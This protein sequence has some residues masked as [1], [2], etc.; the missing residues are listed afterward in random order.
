MEFRTLRYFIKVAES[1]S[2]SSAAEKLKLSQ[3]AL[4]RQ[5]QMMEDELGLS[6]FDRAG[7]KVF[8]TAAGVD[9]LERAYEVQKAVSSLTTRASELA[10]GTH[11]IIRV[12]ATPQ[13]LESLISLTLP[14]F[15][16]KHPGAQILLMES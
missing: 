16:S 4:S 7:R 13:T 15:Q 11:G 2:F 1:L 6:L 5:I 3:S 10:S 12:G 14:K 9:L 8:L